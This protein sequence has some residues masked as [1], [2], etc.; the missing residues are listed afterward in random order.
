MNKIKLTYDESRMFI[1]SLANYQDLDIQVDSKRD[2]IVG[3]DSAQTKVFDFKF[4]ICYPPTLSNKLS[5]FIEKIPQKPMPFLVLLVQAGHSAMGYFEEGEVIFHKV[6]KKYMV[7]KKQGKAQLSFLKTRGK[8]R[9]GSRIRLANS[10]AFFE[11]I[12]TKLTQW[13]AKTADEKMILYSC[14]AQLWGLLFK[15]KVSPPFDRKSNF[16][17]KVSRNGNQ[18][19]YEEL[20]RTG[21]YATYGF[22]YL[23]Q[24]YD[25]SLSNIKG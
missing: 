4:P 22:I 15:S 14:S 25:L 13:E 3:Y 11:D 21:R 20:L 5:S 24:E 16:L 9:L 6:I 1:H 17:R 12:N 19:G 10:I 8:S 18:P 23:Y 2:A 7:R